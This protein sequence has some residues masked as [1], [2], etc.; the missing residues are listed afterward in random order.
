M[1]D[2]EGTLLV[3]GLFI[4]IM[5]VFGLIN[6]IRGSVKTDEKLDESSEEI[7]ENPGSPAEF[8]K[9]GSEDWSDY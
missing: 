3:I 7:D 2:A 5:A 8:Y 9:G 1:T 6:K 4:T